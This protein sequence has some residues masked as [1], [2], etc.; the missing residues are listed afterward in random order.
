[1]HTLVGE[2]FAN[3]FYAPAIFIFTIFRRYNATYDVREL[4]GMLKV[5]LLV[6]RSHVP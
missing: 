6:D 1:M 2:Q 5:N 4:L 3:T